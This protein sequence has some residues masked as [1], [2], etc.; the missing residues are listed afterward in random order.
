MAQLLHFD[1]SKR[2][3]MKPIKSD[4]VPI[5][6][7]MLFGVRN[8]LSAKIAGQSARTTRVEKR[9]D[10]IEKRMD[11]LEKRMGNLEKRMDNLEQS[12]ANLIL[13]M[14][15]LT[16]EVHRIGLLV[17]QQNANNRYVLDGYAMIYDRQ[18][19]L[20]D[21]QIKFEQALNKYIL[22]QKDM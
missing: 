11:A 16:A 1:P 9:M 17:E 18:D 19:K 22:S 8:E 12:M 5:T 7:E 2:I 3:K 14:Q 21:R 4:K 13:E 15:R 10:T 6:K 20:D